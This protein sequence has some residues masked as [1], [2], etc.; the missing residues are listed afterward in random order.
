VD[1]GDAGDALRI[2]ATAD[3]AGLSDSRRSRHLIDVALAHSYRRDTSAMVATLL[4][5]EHF[6]PERLTS[7]ALVREMLYG[8]LRRERGLINAEL[9]ALADRVGAT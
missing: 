7:S 9:H 6:A 4:E 3:L 5:V 8:A 1:L 2:A